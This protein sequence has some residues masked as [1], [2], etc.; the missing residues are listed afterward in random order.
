M[1]LT[2]SSKKQSQHYLEWFLPAKYK[3]MPSS[4]VRNDVFRFNTRWKAGFCIEMLVLGEFRVFLQRSSNSQVFKDRVIILT[5][6][7]V[8]DTKRRP[9]IVRKSDIKYSS[10]I[11]RRSENN[12]VMRWAEFITYKI[13]WR[14]LYATLKI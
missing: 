14:S 13:V 5:W 2:P 1:R 10:D 12:G 9:S 11:H 7:I 6:L 3:L 4:I 8:S